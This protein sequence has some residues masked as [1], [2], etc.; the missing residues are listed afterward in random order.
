MS[1]FC[2]KMGSDKVVSVGN[3]RRTSSSS[4]PTRCTVAEWTRCAR[5][6]CDRAPEKISCCAVSQLGICKSCSAI[7]IF[8]WQLTACGVIGHAKQASHSLLPPQDDQLRLA[9]CLFLAAAHSLVHHVNLSVGLTKK[10]ENSAVRLE[11]HLQYC[12]VVGTRLRRRKSG[13]VV[14]CSRCSSSCLAG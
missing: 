5:A 6:C 14:D 9:E 13:I 10:I 12:Y 3:L 1:Q 7:A 8:C 11:D 2:M 4:G